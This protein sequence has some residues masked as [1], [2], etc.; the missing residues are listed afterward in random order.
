MKKTTRQR[1]PDQQ[2]RDQLAN[3]KVVALRVTADRADAVRNTQQTLTL[4]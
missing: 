2:H 3:W 1:K 4:P